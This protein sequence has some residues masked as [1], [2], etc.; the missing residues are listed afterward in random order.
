MY[1]MKISMDSMHRIS[2]IG[3]SM[4]L[5]WMLTV[6]RGGG[7]PHREHARRSEFPVQV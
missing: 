6:G 2:I 1:P 7:H 5:N 4:H 3:T